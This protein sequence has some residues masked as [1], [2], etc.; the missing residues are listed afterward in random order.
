MNFS[1]GDPCLGMF[2][3]VSGEPVG[4]TSSLSTSQ[5]PAQGIHASHIYN[6]ILYSLQCTSVHSLHIH[7]LQPG[8]LKRIV[9]E[10]FLQR[11][12]SHDELMMMVSF[13][14]ALLFW[15]CSTDP[16]VRTFVII[17]LYTVYIYILYIYSLLTL[18]ETNVE[19]RSMG[20]QT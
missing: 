20:W 12:S 17:L 5:H 2:R 8:S 15:T 18:P 1:G 13:H 11:T 16:S 4:W 6:F 3:L 7:S 10:V 9:A 19:V 14:F